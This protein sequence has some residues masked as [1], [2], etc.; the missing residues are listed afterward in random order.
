MRIVEI[1]GEANFPQLVVESKK[2]FAT[3][4]AVDAEY[5]QHFDI[6]ESP[7]V[8]GFLKTNL[9]DLANH[10]HALYQEPAFVDDQATSFAEASRWYGQFLYSFPED[11]ETPQINYQLADLLLEN[12]NFGE[13]ALEY[14]RTAY[15]YAP[16][17]QAAA[18]GYAAVYA[19]R[20]DL[21]VATGLEAVVDVVD[22]VVLVVLVVDGGEFP[23]VRR[24]LPG[25]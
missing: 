11:E 19:H 13:S 20:E 21:A 15:D 23:E 24:H 22:D 4:Y 2:E 17:E 14:E 12:K 16:H 10:Y 8:V 18:A 7:E 1:Y 9:T 25:S 3:R 6:A 5:W